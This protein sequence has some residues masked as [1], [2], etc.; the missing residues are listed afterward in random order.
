M[1]ILDLFT[2]PSVAPVV[3]TPWERGYDHGAAGIPPSPP[4]SPSQVPMQRYFAGYRAAT[5]Y[6]AQ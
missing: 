5:A 6:G 3:S 4:L 2:P 1:N